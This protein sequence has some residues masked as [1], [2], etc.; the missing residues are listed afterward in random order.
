MYQALVKHVPWVLVFRVGRMI[1][2]ELS[3]DAAMLSSMKE[4]GEME[5]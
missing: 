2:Q 4:T 3:R 1:S 5:G